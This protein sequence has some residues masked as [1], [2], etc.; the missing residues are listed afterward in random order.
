MH[1]LNLPYIV[2]DYETSSK[3]RDNSPAAYFEENFAICLGASMYDAGGRLVE[4]TD[5][6]DEDRVAE[7]SEEVYRWVCSRSP[8]V[9]V[10]HNVSFD[11]QWLLRQL[12]IDKSQYL[13]MRV[14]EGTLLLHDTQDMAYLLSGH[15]QKGISLMKL[16]EVL[17]CPHPK[18]DFLQKLFEEGKTAVDADREDL[19][20]Y[21][22]RDIDSTA[23][24]YQKMMSLGDADTMAAVMRAMNNKGVMCL[25]EAEGL[26]F[27]PEG[28]YYEAH[29]LVSQHKELHEI[30]VTNVEQLYDRESDV[31][32]PDVMFEIDGS[33]CDLSSTLRAELNPDSSLYDKATDGELKAAFLQKFQTPVGLAALLQS[34][35]DDEPSC[36]VKIKRKHAVGVFKNGSLKYK[37]VEHVVKLGL[38]KIDF[39]P[40]AEVAAGGDADTLKTYIE[41]MRG[42]GFPPSL[43]EG[44]LLAAMQA[45][46]TL[47]DLEKQLSTYYNPLI[48]QA[49]DSYDGRVHHRLNTARTGTGRLSSSNPNGQ[50]MPGKDK[51]KLKT[52]FREEGWMYV[53]GDFKQVEVIGLAA[54]T[55][56]PALIKTL[57]DGVD[58]HFKSG[59]TVYGWKD[60]SE[61]TTPLK[62]IVKGVNFG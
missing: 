18:T 22:E 52:F 4:K 43:S 49:N 35:I 55:K 41:H 56:C 24:C 30:L 6:H 17:A 40:D 61:M 25:A 8:I 39:T 36:S 31:I 7:Y 13:K 62:R 57:L 47:R 5:F 50:N 37:T 3:G 32:I 23:W 51:S 48:R 58:M 60:P 28:A 10:G 20:T 38:L 9:L 42:T 45:L 16:C 11:F 15:Q 59:S 2:F 34:S 53:E 12:P 1:P 14:A 44:N 33:P 46:L 29:D 26:P 27:D 19:F 54:R 21:C